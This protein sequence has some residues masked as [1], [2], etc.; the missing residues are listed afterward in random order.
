M[1]LFG[2]R[3]APGAQGARRS[4]IPRRVP[5]YRLV[6]SPAD[7]GWLVLRGHEPL[8]TQHR[9]GLARA[10]LAQRWAANVVAGDGWQVDAWQRRDEHDDFTASLRG[11]VPKR[12][13]QQDVRPEQVMRLIRLG[14][15]ETDAADLIDHDAGPFERAKAELDAVKARSTQ[16]ELRAA[17]DALRRH[18]Y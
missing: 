8:A 2:R 16:S 10:D 1:T 18:G 11:R 5:V 17:A 7:V 4:W 14:M 9:L 13:S 15:R 12:V 3:P 6:Y